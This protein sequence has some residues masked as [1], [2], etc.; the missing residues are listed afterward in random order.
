MPGSAA[1]LF[2]SATARLHRSPSGLGVMALGLAGAG[3]LSAPLAQSHDAFLLNATPSE[4][5]GLYRRLEA[6]PARGRLVAFRA[7]PAAFP[8]ADAKLGYLRRVTLLKAVAGVA[9]DE[10]C[11]RT[12]R[13]VINGRDRAPIAAADEAGRA[14]PH[15][16]GCRALSAGEVF[17]YS[18]RVPNS[19]D[20]RYFGP[21]PAASIVGVYAPLLVDG[22]G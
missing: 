1:E 6:A 5:V 16:S 7:P 20:S 21:V 11:T 3:A 12:G 17:V 9:G 22:E 2:A 15:W 4:P 8:Y 14:L 19:F 18:A 13:L 10:V